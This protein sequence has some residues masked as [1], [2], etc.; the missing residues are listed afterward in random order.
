M[1]RGKETTPFPLSLRP[2]WGRRGSLQAGAWFGRSCDPLG[3][4]VPACSGPG[5]VAQ[6][7]A[8]VGVTAEP[9]LLALI[10]GRGQEVGS[11]PVAPCPAGP[12]SLPSGQ[13]EA[14]LGW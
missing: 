4:S 3:S 11:M 8:G 7:C 1:K 10:L 6:L 12:G 14:A 2:F 9:L 13:G 5:A